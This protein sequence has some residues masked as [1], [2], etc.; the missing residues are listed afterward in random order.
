[1]GLKLAN[2]A[3]STLAASINTAVTSLAVAS[4]D[5][6]KFPTLG[7]GDWFPLTIV[8]PSGNMEVVR[9]TARSG[10]TLTIVRAQEGTTAKSFAAGSKCDVRLTAAALA[11]LPI[12]VSTISGTLPDGQLPAT[13]T[14][15]TFSSPIMVQGASST[16]DSAGD[17]ALNIMTDADSSWR[18][19]FSAS[20]NT[21]YLQHSTDQYTSNFS[22]MMALV[23][24]NVVWHSGNDGAG[25]GLDA[26]LLDGLNAVS[27]AATGNTVVART[28]SGAIWT[29]DIF[30]TRGD[31]T[32]A[33]QFGGNATGKYLYY[34]NT[35]FQFLGAGLQLDTNQA[36]SFQGTG[37]ATT[38]ANLGFTGAI[39]AWVNFNGTGTPGI[40]AS[41][42]VS[43]ITDNGVGDYTVNFSNAFADTNYAVF[44]WARY[45]VNASNTLVGT[46]AWASDTKT[47]GA[48]RIRV[49]YSDPGSTGA[50]D[51]PEVNVM[52]V[53]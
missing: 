10:A 24:G 32:G 21:M 35:N 12:D 2:N 37:A 16:F 44:A 27:A 45:A 17:F 25:S 36:I 51:S 20:T 46:F 28:A 13:M 38:R 43:S 30:A 47:T 4:G 48:V 7:A 19:Y 14:G 53:R 6:S 5:A 42:N 1:M 33:I 26:D 18:F 9:V 8:D 22:N 40:R 23:P 11:A 50:H 34:N 15:K 49:Q 31:G 41:G 29:Q 39:A 52:V 3:V